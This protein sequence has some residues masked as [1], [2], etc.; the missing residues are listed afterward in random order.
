VHVFAG[1]L[2]ADHSRVRTPPAG[3]RRQRGAPVVG[4]RAPDRAVVDEGKT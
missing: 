3:A 4:E 1:A 2:E